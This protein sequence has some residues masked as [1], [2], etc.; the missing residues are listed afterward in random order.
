[1][2]ARHHHDGHPRLGDRPQRRVGHVGDGRRGLGLIEDVS[3]VDDEIHLP[4]QGRSQRALVRGQEVEPPDPSA[5][6]HPRRMVVP[7]VGI[8][9]DQ[10]PNARH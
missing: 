5:G 7:D 9:D 4:G 2:V 3:G 8:G 1:M 6:S 10:D